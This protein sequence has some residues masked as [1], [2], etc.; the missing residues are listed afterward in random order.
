M[1]NMELITLKVLRKDSPDSPSYW[2][3]FDVRSTPGSN[4]ISLLMEIQKNPV[5]QEGKR[6]SPVQW[7]CSCLEEV[8]GACS[9]IINGKVRQACSSL[10]KDLGRKIVLEP[11][12]KFPVIR[13]LRVDRTRMFDDLKEIHAWVPIEGTYDLGPGP[14]LDEMERLRAYELS[15]CMTCGLCLEAC[16]KV[17]ERSQ[18]IGPASIA[19]VRRFN[20]HP[21]G[22]TYREIRLAEM[23]GPRGV[24]ACDNSQNCEKACP[25]GL[26]LVRTIAEVKKEALGQLFRH[27]FNR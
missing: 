7:D 1:V 5:T 8:C 9:M 13:D 4:V 19:Q 3:R 11:L 27:I 21:H 12:S 17:N 6:V 25:K 24:G 16:P 10:V 23:I 20:I 26:P 14:H 22:G 15:R 2:Q 18:F